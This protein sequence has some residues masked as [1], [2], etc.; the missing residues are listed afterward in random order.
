[1]ADKKDA[2]KISQGGQG[3][4]VSLYTWDKLGKVEQMQPTWKW[5][6]VY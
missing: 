5:K 4:S 3:D 2:A 1:M 6:K